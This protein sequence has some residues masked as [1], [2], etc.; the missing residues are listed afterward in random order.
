MTK[1]REVSNLVL[2]FHRDHQTIPQFKDV[3]L[4]I[5]WCMAQS[6]ESDFIVIPFL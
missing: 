3:K 2:M 1:N 4:R 5:S 6:R